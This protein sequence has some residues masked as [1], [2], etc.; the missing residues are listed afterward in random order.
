MDKIIP[1]SVPSF[2]GNEKKYVD[3]T[4]VTEW[5]STAGSFVEAFEKKISEYNGSQNAVACAN[6]TSALHITLLESGVSQND[7]V[8]VPAVTFIAPINTVRYAGAQ[9][10]FMDCDDHLNID[11]KKVEQFIEDECDFDGNSLKN[12]SSKRA[13]K[14]ILPVHVF[15]HPVDMEYLM[16]LAQRYKL[17]V[18]EDATESLGSTYTMG[19]YKGKRTG[20][21][22]DYGCYSFNGNKII[23]TGGG[24]MIVTDNAKAASHMHYLTNQAKD[25]DVYFIHH[26]VGFNY[27]MTNLQAALGLAQLELLDKYIEIKRRNFQ[28]YRSALD[29]HKGL[30][31]IEEPEYS[32]SNYW[33]YTLVVER[34]Q[35]SLSRD[36]LLQ[37]LSEKGIQTRPLWYL[38]HLQKPYKD[39]QSYKIE[40]AHWFYERVLSIPCSVGLREEEIDR[41]VS[42]IKH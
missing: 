41:V 20:S 4:I 34:D 7:E 1:L 38:N 22:G 35:Y 15:G 32:R 36:E 8:I 6:G 37:K 27:R 10:V 23:T 39:C 12:R 13:I 2:Q 33:F 25:D 28:R 42:E 16:D 19:K 30:F 9:P 40:K 18:I 5:V 29:G 17:T 26:E 14:A 31:F 3:E 11:V 24:G 21:I